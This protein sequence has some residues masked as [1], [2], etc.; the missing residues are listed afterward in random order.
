MDVQV[1]ICFVNFKKRVD[2]KNKFQKTNFKKRFS[3]EARLVISDEK[4]EK[5]LVKAVPL[6]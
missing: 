3:E 4:Q 1:R 2:M 6:S 5:N